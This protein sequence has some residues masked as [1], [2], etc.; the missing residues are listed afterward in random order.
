MTDQ[1]EQEIQQT[2]EHLAETVDA[3]TTKA[4]TGGRRVLVI[5]LPALVLMIVGVVLWRRR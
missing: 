5:G 4:A 1:L 3:L 2:R